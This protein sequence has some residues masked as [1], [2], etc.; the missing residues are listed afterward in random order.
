MLVTTDVRVPLIENSR[1][2]LWM[3]DS[4]MEHCTAI[5]GAASGIMERS[6]ILYHVLF[7]W[8]LNQAHSLPLLSWSLC[9]S[10]QAWHN[11]AFPQTSVVI[12]PSCL[13]F[14]YILLTCRQSRLIN[15]CHPPPLLL[16]LLPLPSGG[17][18]FVMCVIVTLPAPVSSAERGWDRA[19]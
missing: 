8:S 6:R 10:H 12:F 14:T 17:L 19:G 16:P 11:F 7:S 18:A 1:G 5:S 13:V 3:L 9:H 4:K 15:S 2:R